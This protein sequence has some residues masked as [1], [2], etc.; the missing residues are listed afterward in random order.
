M[1][2][3]EQF[4]L[5][6]RA[7]IVVGGGRGIG[8]GVARAYASAGASIALVARTAEQAQAVADDLGSQGAKAIVVQADV[9]DFDTLPG[10]VARTVEEF[11]RIDNLTYSAGG[12]YD[13]APYQDLNLEGLQTSLDRNIKVPFELVR[14]AVPYLSKSPNASIL[15]MSS[16]TTTMRLRGHLLYEV[17]KAGQNQL[18]RSLSADLGPKIRVNSILPNAIETGGLQLA[19]DDNPGL[20]DALTERIHMRRLGRPDDIGNAALFLASDAATWVTGVLLEVSGGPVD[21][22]GDRYPDL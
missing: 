6:G 5:D 17:S 11:G 9:Y 16:I 14:L 8:E 15:L 18:T 7:A 13:W 1:D 10:I 20:R 21:G 4:S 22:V 2:G 12:G 3:F 19:F